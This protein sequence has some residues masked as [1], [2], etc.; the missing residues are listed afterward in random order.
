MS[1]IQNKYIFNQCLYWVSQKKRNP[2]KLIMYAFSIY[3]IELHIGNQ[4]KYT[5]FYLV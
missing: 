3:I 5:Y 4:D 1:K 2:N